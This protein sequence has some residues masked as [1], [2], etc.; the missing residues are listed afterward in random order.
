MITTIRDL[1][2]EVDL[3]KEKTITRDDP[4]FKK[5]NQADLIDLD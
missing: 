4:D 1:R 5:L 2:F 3:L